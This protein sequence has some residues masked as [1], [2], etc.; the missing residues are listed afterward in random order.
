M[1]VSSF[2]KPFCASKEM[3]TLT[4][5][6]SIGACSKLE[7]FV[8]DFATSTGMY[9]Y[10]HFTVALDFHS[11]IS[12]NIFFIS[13]NSVLACCNLGQHILAL[14]GNLEVFDKV[15]LSSFSR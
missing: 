14:H 4:F 7:S 3:H 10:K 15:S 13:G 5:K 8:I 12:A 11:E 6:P 9:C 1:I 2:R